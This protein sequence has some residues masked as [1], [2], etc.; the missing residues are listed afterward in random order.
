LVDI[1]FIV[2]RDT[3]CTLRVR[4]VA[5]H[6][7]A[8]SAL[9]I[10]FGCIVLKPKDSEKAAIFVLGV[11][12]PRVA[13]ASALPS[14]LPLLLLLLLHDL[15]DLLKSGSHDTRVERVEGN[16]NQ[17]QHHTATEHHERTGTVVA[18]K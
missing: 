6:L 13:D 11:H 4:M 9:D 17:E 2:A 18:A 10:R 15:P 14:M 12:K 7:L 5:L 8:K 3:R 16:R 1:A